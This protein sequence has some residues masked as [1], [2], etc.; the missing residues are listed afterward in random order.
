MRVKIATWNVNGIRACEK[1]GFFDWL[2]KSNVD[3]ACLQEVRAW[4]EQLINKE[5]ID[6]KKYHIH[7]AIAEKKGY[8]GVA[9]FSKKNKFKNPSVTIGLGIK[10]FDREGRTIIA[11]YD[12]F[13]LFSCYFPNGQ[14][15]H[16]RVPYKLAYSRAVAQKALA[17]TKKRKKPI[18]I[19][20]DYNT[21][22]CEIDLKN[23]KSNIN[24]TGF[25]P[26]ERAW[27]DQ[28]IGQGF[29]DIFRE[30]HPEEEGHYTWWTYRN[31]C[32]EKN[33]GWRIDYFFLTEELREK[34]KKV[35]HC[36]EVMGSD[37]CPVN[38]ELKF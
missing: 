24:S 30:R 7:Y 19:A 13:I 9:L 21:A 35:Y 3:I 37:H 34:T 8:S 16:G 5:L 14:N 11:E 18:I 2:K 6:N 36:P 27:I 29:Y 28:F 20:G 31:N 38:I 22:H 10:K 15:D 26:R 1:K 12:D 4:P 32:R 33:V 17:L 25:L 23:P